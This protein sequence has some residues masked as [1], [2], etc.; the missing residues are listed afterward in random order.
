MRLGVA[1]QCSFALLRDK[2]QAVA[3]E[4]D[5]SGAG[6]G[7]TIKKA[8]VYRRMHGWGYARVYGETLRM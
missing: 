5:I 3:G 8:R 6:G 1:D 2:R 7:V 4:E